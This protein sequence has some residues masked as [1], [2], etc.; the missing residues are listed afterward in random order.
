M[1]KKQQASP[2][3]DFWLASLPR[4]PEILQVMVFNATFNNISAK[5]WQ[6]IQLVEETGELWEN[7]RM[8]QKKLK[9][10]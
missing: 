6:S 9:K 3:I 4:T 2:V 5:L 10:Y 1:V 8:P 7:H